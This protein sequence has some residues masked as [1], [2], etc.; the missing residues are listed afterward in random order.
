MNVKSLA[1]VIFIIT[2]PLYFLSTFRIASNLFS[3]RAL[4]LSWIGSTSLCY[5]FTLAWFAGF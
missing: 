4:Y 3:S 5:S 1:G 2:T